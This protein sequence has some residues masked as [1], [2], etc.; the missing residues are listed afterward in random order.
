MTEPRPGTGRLLPHRRFVLTLV[1]GVMALPAVSAS[2]EP[3]PDVVTEVTG[4]LEPVG[5]GQLRWMGFRV[6]EATLWTRA[7]VYRE[8]ERPFALAIRYHRDIASARLVDTTLDEMTRLGIDERR[9]RAWK[10]RLAAVLPDVHSGDRLIGTALPDR[11]TLFVHER[12]GGDNGSVAVTGLIDDAAFTA[13][14]FD[15]WLDENTS[16]RRLRRALVGG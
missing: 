14:F 1:L 6:Y 4:T 9:M 11:G 13:A 5:T 2:H 15:I 8:G 12:G 10:S 7:G 3:L 16:E